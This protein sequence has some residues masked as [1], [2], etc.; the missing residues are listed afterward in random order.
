[1]NLASRV[2]RARMAHPNATPVEG[3]PGLFMVGVPPQNG[4]PGL[5]LILDEALNT[6]CSATNGIE[7]ILLWLDQQWPDFPVREAIVVERDSEG[8]FDHAYP[9]WAVRGG[10]DSDVPPLVHWKPLRW[11][12]AHP[13]TKEA[14]LGVFG[15]NA[16]TALNLANEPRD[17]INDL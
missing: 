6:G 15:A 11:V 1:M 9:E 2:T 17:K 5:I 7:R 8:C 14:F 16:R 13:R 4:F 3:Q 10:H 12:G